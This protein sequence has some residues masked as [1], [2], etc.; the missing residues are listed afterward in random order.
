MASFTTGGTPYSPPK[1]PPGVPKGKPGGPPRF[2]NKASGRMETKQAMHAYRAPAAQ[3]ITATKGNT[4][5]TGGHGNVKAPA[6]SWLDMNPSELHSYATRSVQQNTQA[7]LQ[8]Y[9]QK[10]GEIY[11]TEQAVAGRFGGYGQ[12]TDQQLQGLQ[13]QAAEGAKTF[14]NQVADTALK[15]RQGVETTGQNAQAQNAGYLDPQL[16]AA[17]AAQQGNVA[18]TG[19]AQ[20]GAAQQMGQ[21]E[22]SFMANL[23]AAATQR[24]AEGQQGI[25][26]NYGKQQAANT[27]AQN[28]LLGRQPGAITKLET[29]LGQ[30]QRNTQLAEIGLTGK[31][32]ATA[33]KATE[34]RERV[35][36][37]IR[38]QNVGAETTRR[39]QNITAEHNAADLGYK[40]ASLSEKTRIDN[41]SIQEKAAKIQALLTKTQKGTPVS[42]AQVK[43]S[44]ELGAAY[45][46][47]R[48]LRSGPKGEMASPKEVR[49]ILTRGR[50]G[51]RAMPKVENQVLITAAQELWYT[52]RVSKATRALMGKLGMNIGT[53]AEAFRAVDGRG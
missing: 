50:E 23:R 33:Q 47:F 17:L 46:T 9:R 20:Q 53:D 18:A 49:E 34:T 5:V 25:A 45:N 2:L 3:R 11:G 41:A 6:K 38:G 12:A 7:E 19:Q 44:T 24:V 51:K 32:R 16:R 27:Q 37:T 21:N 4:T 10:A 31:E 8:P 52:H 15:A 30:K 48:T 43:L 13:S 22:Q 28:Q 39:G 35:G 29:E 1:G 14:N 42:P 36:A 40:N 26:A